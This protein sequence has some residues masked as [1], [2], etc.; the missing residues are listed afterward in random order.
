MADFPQS[1]ALKL[2][3]PDMENPDFIA[4]SQVK[5]V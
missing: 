3:L 1:Q 5:S 4:F 2:S